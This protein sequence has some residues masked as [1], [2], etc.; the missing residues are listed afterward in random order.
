MSCSSSRFPS[1]TQSLKFGNK[2][3]SARCLRCFAALIPPLI[4]NSFLVQQ[5]LWPHVGGECVMMFRPQLGSCS[6]GWARTKQTRQG[7]TLGIK[8]EENN[9]ITLYI[10][11]WFVWALQRHDFTSFVPFNEC[12]KDPIPTV[13]SGDIHVESRAYSTGCIA[14]SSWVCLKVSH[15]TKPQP[16]GD[17]YRALGYFLHRKYHQ[18]LRE[19]STKTLLVWWNGAVNPCKSP[20][21]TGDDSLDPEVPKTLFLFFGVCSET[22]NDWWE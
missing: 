14:S 3:Q 17:S 2:M 10:I 22:T 11:I 15:A 18:I 13:W 21:A 6:F 7:S 1:N 16:F 19:L 8:L 5:V 12:P 4:S 20:S 9:Y